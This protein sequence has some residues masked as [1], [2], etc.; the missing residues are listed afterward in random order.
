MSNKPLGWFLQFRS[1]GGKLL[2]WFLWFT[3][4]QDRNERDIGAMGQEDGS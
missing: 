3:G 1:M 4:K 2:G